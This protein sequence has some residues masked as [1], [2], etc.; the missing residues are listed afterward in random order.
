MAKWETNCETLYYLGNIM[1]YKNFCSLSRQPSSCTKQSDSI[2]QSTSWI[3]FIG[4]VFQAWRIWST[5]SSGRQDRLSSE[6]DKI[7]PYSLEYLP[8]QFH[9]RYLFPSYSWQDS[10]S[11]KYP[12]SQPILTRPSCMLSKNQLQKYVSHCSQ[13]QNSPVPFHLPPEKELQNEWDDSIDDWKISGLNELND[14]RHHAS[15]RA[16]LSI[17]KHLKARWRKFASWQ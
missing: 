6:D 15:F 7:L 2:K 8:D 4:H 12:L 17:T 14:F 1:L 11:Q 5:S 9:G 3:Y 16:F 13:G 10:Q